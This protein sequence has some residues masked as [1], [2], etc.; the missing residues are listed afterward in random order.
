M[1]IAWFVLLV[2]AFTDFMITVA[3]ALTTA[4]VA[5]G[6][7]ELPGKPVLVLALL[8]GLASAGRTIQQAL[9]AT[10]ESTAVLKGD[11]ASVSTVV[12]TKTVEPK[13]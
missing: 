7:A 12:M 1:K 3:T 2:S 11:Q 5:M 10:P 6:P 13:V 9:K 4:M 8:G